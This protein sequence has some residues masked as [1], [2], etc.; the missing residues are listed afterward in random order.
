[1][2][3]DDEMMIYQLM[4]EDDAFD[5]DIHEHLSMLSCI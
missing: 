3:I 1:M 2:D 5:T 4:E